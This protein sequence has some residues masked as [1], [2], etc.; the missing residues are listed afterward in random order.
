MSSHLSP[1]FEYV[2][3][4]IDCEQSLFSLKI[5]GEERKTNNCASVT[6]SVTYQGRGA[7]LPTPTLL[8][9]GSLIC[10]AF[11]HTVFEEERDCS[12]SIYHMVFTSTLYICTVNYYKN[13]CHFTVAVSK[14]SKFFSWTICFDSHHG[15][16]GICIWVASFLVEPF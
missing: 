9:S 8:L 16:L 7:N 2:I 14:T 12:Q 1:L 11:F 13:L 15:D 3:F 6:V 4:H 5:C 10:F